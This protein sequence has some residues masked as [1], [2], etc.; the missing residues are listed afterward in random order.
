MTTRQKTGVFGVL[1]AVLVRFKRITDQPASEPASNFVAEPRTRP[2][3]R[4]ALSTEGFSF[5][6]GHD[7]ADVATWLT[8][9]AEGRAAVL[10]APLS[11]NR[12]RGGRVGR[13]LGPILE[14]LDWLAF[15]EHPRR[16]GDLAIA[17]SE[18]A[19]L[20][21]VVPR[22]AGAAGPVL[23]ADGALAGAGR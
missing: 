23:A 13:R 3:R 15:I 9:R 12:L 6:E 7:V 10:A 11:E 18:A 21:S 2:F 5:F 14:N 19:G 4:K 22:L 17:G 8:L 20:R 16:F 1:T